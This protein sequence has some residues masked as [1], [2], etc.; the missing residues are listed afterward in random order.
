MR[1]GTTLL[2][3][4]LNAHPSLGMTYTQTDFWRFAFRKFD[5]LDKDKCVALVDAMQSRFK[6]NEGDFAEPIKEGILADTVVSRSRPTYARI[7]M[8]LL[9]RLSGKSAMR[10]GE[11]YAGQCMEVPRFLET[12][13]NG[14]VILIHRDARDVLAS[15]IKRLEQINQAYIDRMEYLLNMYYWRFGIEVAQ[16]WRSHTGKRRNFGLVSYERLV[17][18]PRDELNTLCDFLEIPYSDQML[19]P[20]NYVDGEGRP[21]TANSSFDRDVRNVEARFVGR[22]TSVLNEREREYVETYCRD[23][24]HDAGYLRHCHGPETE[25]FRPGHEI[26]IL[27]RKTE[28]VAGLHARYP[29]SAPYIEREIY[30]QLAGLVS[31]PREVIRRGIVIVG[32]A[33]TALLCRLLLS[34]LDLKVLAFADRVKNT[35]IWLDVP[36]LPIRKALEFNPGVLVMTEWNWKIGL[37]I[38]QWTADPDPLALP[39]MVFVKRSGGYSGTSHSLFRVLGRS[40]V[41]VAAAGKKITGDNLLSNSDFKSWSNTMPAGWEAGGNESR[42]RPVN[43]TSFP[44]GFECEMTGGLNVS[45]LEQALQKIEALDDADLYFGC[46]VRTSVPLT[47]RL[48]IH[49]DFGQAASEYHSG[50]GDWEYLVAA[51]YVPKGIKLVSVQIRV[52]GNNLV[53]FGQAVAVSAATG[54]SEM[55]AAWNSEKTNIREGLVSQ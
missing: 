48:E 39:Q 40:I 5:P 25:R 26:Q 36:V 55:G 19:D 17:T 20:N 44:G 6:Q 13:P 2:N 28:E 4:L 38:L 47:V 15:D 14:Q 34:E 49:S 8:S 50:A 24:L 11:K 42:F 32:T 37:D 43:S 31:L 41:P 46:W 9:S 53:A 12:F 52:F 30:E 23:A 54:L 22:W 35:G 7:Y 27:M 16:E 33:D 3:R 1:S 45:W 21:W 29:V 51:M 18:S 10:W